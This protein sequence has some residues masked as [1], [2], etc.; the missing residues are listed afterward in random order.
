MTIRLSSLIAA[1]LLAVATSAAAQ[2]DIPVYVVHTPGDNAALLS[3]DD[4]A[5]TVTWW[6]DRDAPVWVLR[7]SALVRESRTPWRVDAWTVTTPGVV[8][9]R[10][11]RYDVLRSAD[12]GPVPREVQVAIRPRSF[13]LEAAYDPTLVFTD[14]SVA[15]Y[16]EQ[17]DMIPVAD[18]E[19]AR[20]LPADISGVPMPVG[21][22]Q[23]TW[24]DDRGPVLLGGAREALPSTRAPN[25]YVLFGDP[26]LNETPRVVTVTDPALPIWIDGEIERFAPRVID[27]FTARLGPALEGRPMI[28]ASWSGPTSGVT[29]MGGS[30]LPGLIV[31]TFEG[32]G[33]LRATDQVTYAAH[34]FIGHESA[35]FWLGQKVAYER[36]RDA[37]IT[38]GGADLMA[39]RAL[40]ALDPT[41]DARE[42]LQKEVDDCISL[43]TGRSVETAETRGEHRAYYACGAVFAMAAEGV[44][45]GDWFAFLKPLLD[46]SADDKVLTRAEWLGALAARPGG[47]ALVTDIET[48]LDAGAADPRLVVERLLRGAGVGV[49]REGGRVVLL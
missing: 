39:I 42:A 1:A 15:F 32:E 27:F 29:S 30:T 5:F 13:D 34:W 44:T 6:L 19:A 16:S 47:P 31:M 20:A 24:R 33:V 48:L 37:W 23:V 25:T 22:M 3:R 7:E 28:M 36:P 12:G 46:A 10:V 21:P 9:E 40:K 43:S 35:H 2:T 14:G 18:I 8:L 4:G 17:F 41:Y 11:G 45:G 49:R 26:G 38:E